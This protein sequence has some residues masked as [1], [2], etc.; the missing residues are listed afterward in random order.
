LVN[1]HLMLAVKNHR[2]LFSKKAICCSTI[3]IFAA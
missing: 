3:T 2:H 1:F